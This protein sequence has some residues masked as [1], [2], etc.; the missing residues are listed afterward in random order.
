MFLVMIVKF[1]YKMVFLNTKCYILKVGKGLDF[2]KVSIVA[3]VEIFVEFTE[4]FYDSFFV[5]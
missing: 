3:F 4:F 2:R 1:E 5:Y